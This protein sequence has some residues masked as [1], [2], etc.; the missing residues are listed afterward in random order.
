MKTLII[1][2][3]FL[4]I[5]VCQSTSLLIPMDETQRNHLKA[6]GIAFYALQEDM[7]V[8]WLLNYRGGSFLMEF[9]SVIESEC[10]IRGISY[11][12]ISS[13]ETHGILRQIESPSY[14]MH[15]VRM[16]RAPKIAVYSPRNEMIED[17]T[18]A[19]LL[20]LDYAEIPYEIIYDPEILSDELVMF[21][22]LHLHHEDF[23]GQVDKFNWRE[24]ARIENELQIEN[25]QRLGYASVPD[26]KREVVKKITAFLAGGG[27]LFAMCSGAETFDLALSVEELEINPFAYNIVDAELDFERTLAFENFMIEQ[28]YSRRYSDIN[29][30]GG[31]EEDLGYFNIFEFSAKTDIV[32]SIL[33]QNHESAIP[34]FFGRTTAFNRHTVKPSALILGENGENDNVRYIYGELGNG[35]WSY[36]SGH[37]PERRSY[38]GRSR[39]PTD[40]SLYPNSPGY[41]LILNNVLFPSTRKKRQKT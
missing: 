13:V 32:P 15:L 37:D 19:V 8:D 1:L 11:E 17:D 12:V 2:I 4:S 22:W 38:R 9:S 36:Y 18:D 28:G 20:V 3:C 34:E 24:S 23:T 5:S 40:L 35:H 39:A 16:G 33:T 7:S 29:V 31:F 25:A 10:V 6:Y 27:Y 21:D 14:N 41:R 30:G 26:M